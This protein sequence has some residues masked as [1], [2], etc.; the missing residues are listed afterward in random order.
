MTQAAELT[1]DH[2]DKDTD[3]KSLF[4]KAENRLFHA[5]TIENKATGVVIKMTNN[6]EKLYAYMLNQYKWYDGNKRPFSESQVRLGTAARIGDP[7]KNTKRYID[8]LIA[9]G[10]VA[11]P[12]KSGS[13]G[14]CDVYEVFEVDKVA[15]NLV[16]TYPTFED[17]PLYDHEKRLGKDKHSAI[18]AA[19]QEAPQAQQEQ[20]PNEPAPNEEFSPDVVTDLPVPPRESAT[21]KIDPAEVEIF[22]QNGVINEAFIRLTNADRHDDGT[23]KSGW[24]IYAIARTEQARREGLPDAD[25]AAAWD[26]YKAAAKPEYIPLHLHSPTWDTPPEQQNQPGQPAEAA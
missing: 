3:A 9:L 5:K 10:L 18:Q 11:I 6:L 13:R 23:L 21:V 1:D 20:H 2:E 16:F 4:Y 24:Y 26:S 17:K 8:E 25:I 15:K 12:V 22:D 19:Q 14:V 7:V